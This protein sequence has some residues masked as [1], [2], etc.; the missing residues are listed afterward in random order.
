MLAITIQSSS[1]WTRRRRRTVSKRTITTA[2]VNSSVP[3]SGT[4]TKFDNTTL[5]V[6]NT[7]LGP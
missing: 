4:G 6:A 5:F 7:L 2:P 1:G 3:V